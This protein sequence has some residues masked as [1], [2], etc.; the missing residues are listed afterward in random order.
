MNVAEGTEPDYD[1]R[2]RTGLID[3]DGPDQRTHK[4]RM[5]DGDW[6]WGGDPELIA[7]QATTQALTREYLA[8]AETG[9][10]KL[11]EAAGEKLFKRAHWVYVKPPFIIDYGYNTS[12]GQYTFVNSGAV[13]LDAAAITLGRDVLV[14]PNVQFLTAYHPLDPDARRK[15]HAQAKPITVHDDAWI[16]AGSIIMAGVTIGEAAVVGAGSVVTK[17][18]PARTIVAGNP[19]RIIRTL[20]DAPTN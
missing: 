7:E 9:D 12:L 20:D 13:F 8:A 15:Q 5:L 3:P 19:A 10:W 2:D 18:V 17:D 4:Q 6:F 1:W 11:V 14:G 16:G